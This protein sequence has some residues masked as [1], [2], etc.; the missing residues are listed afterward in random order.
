MSQE[1]E[2]ASLTPSTSLL[3]CC[4]L[5]WK[6]RLQQQLTLLSPLMEPRHLSTTTTTTTKM[7]PSLWALMMIKMTQQLEIGVT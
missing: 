2:V 6:P 1:T 7:A 4:W 3:L 5:L